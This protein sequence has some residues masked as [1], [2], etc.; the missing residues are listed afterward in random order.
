MQGGDG[1]FNEVVNGLVMHR[2]KAPAAIMPQRLNSFYKKRSLLQ[3]RNSK[4]IAIS[5]EQGGLK[6][7]LVGDVNT[8]PENSSDQHPLLQNRSLPSLS[9]TTIGQEGKDVISGE[10][11]CTSGVASEGLDTAVSPAK[12]QVRESESREQADVDSSGYCSIS[13]TVPLQDEQG[14]FLQ[15][16]IATAEPIIGT[17]RE[18]LCAGFSAYFVGYV[19]EP[20]LLYGLFERFLLVL[21]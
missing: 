17:E 2:H 20:E 3:Q 15:P 1:F 7:L 4:A 10:D 12:V 19:P 13:L 14:N 5:N 9:K 18:G 8:S 6:Q 11:T 21:D 16:T